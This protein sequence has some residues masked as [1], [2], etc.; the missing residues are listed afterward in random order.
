M[1]N[2]SL[3]YEILE[4]R[5]AEQRR[6]LHNTAQDL[7][8]VVR[9][10]MDVNR[11]LRSHF[12]PLAGAAAVIGLVAGYGLTGIFVDD[13]CERLERHHQMDHHQGCHCNAC[14]A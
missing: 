4:Q 10:K 5:A 2:A 12:A 6:Q 11:Q 14:A 7:R 8:L 13:K 1:T 9:E 3:P